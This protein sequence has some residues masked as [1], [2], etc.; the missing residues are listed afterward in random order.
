MKRKRGPLTHRVGIPVVFSL[1][2][3]VALFASTLA[4][5]A[6]PQQPFIP[7]YYMTASPDQIRLCVGETENIFVFVRLEINADQDGFYYAGEKLKVEVGDREVVRI[8]PDPET[9]T[10]PYSGGLSRR[11]ARWVTRQVPQLNVPDDALFIVT[12]LKTGETK[13]TFTHIQPRTGYVRAAP[14]TV[15]VEVVDCWQAYSWG[16]GITFP[17]KDICG[18][19][20]PFI[21]EAKIPGQNGITEDSNAIFFMPFP[22]QLSSNGNPGG[23]Y[24]YVTRFTYSLGTLTDTGFNVGGGDF[25]VINYQQGEIKEGDIK[26]IGTVTAFHNNGFVVSGDEDTLIA[27]KPLPQSAICYDPLRS[28]GP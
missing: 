3:F 23:S 13:I 18:F 12:A 2:L 17:V 9:Q 15:E 4:Q 20:K 8:Y 16:H 21:L 14:Q 28:V 27:F 11:Q 19:D 10:G 24:V 25:E 1:V 6:P 22:Q 7:I 5:A 26:L